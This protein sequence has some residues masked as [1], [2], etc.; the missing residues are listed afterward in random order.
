MNNAYVYM[1][2]DDGTMTEVPVTVGVSNGNYVE[3]QEGLSDGDTVYVQA[4]EET[5][6]S[7]LS[8]LLS[9]LFGSQNVNCGSMPSGGNSD[10][11][12][13]SGGQ[14]P[15]GFTGS[16]TSGTSSG[17]MSGGPGGSRQQRRGGQLK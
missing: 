4:A 17:G 1:M 16:D 5:T 11:S 8:G 9:G 13:F 7:G 6:S 15:S 14:M 3:I 2:G 10:F 12:G